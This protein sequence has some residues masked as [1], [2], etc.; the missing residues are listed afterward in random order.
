LL[1]GTLN[2]RRHEGRAVFRVTV[3]PFLEVRSPPTCD[4]VHYSQAK[5]LEWTDRTSLEPESASIMITARALRRTSVQRTIRGTLFSFAPPFELANG[6]YCI[7]V[8]FEK[9]KHELQYACNGHS[10]QPYSYCYSTI[11]QLKVTLWFNNFSNHH[12]P[13]GSPQPETFWRA[14]RESFP[15][16]CPPL[17]LPHHPVPHRRSQKKVSPAGDPAASAP[18][19]AKWNWILSGKS[20]A[21]R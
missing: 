11:N 20:S 15:I 6:N 19:S 16:R 5:G 2:G 18:M 4:N 8:S 3:S 21:S 12:S 13:R 1:A 9:D 10:Y 7:D 14:G 17:L